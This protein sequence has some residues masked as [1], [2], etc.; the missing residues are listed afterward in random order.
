MKILLIGEYSNVHWT[1]AE[2]LRELGHKVTVLSNGDFWKDYPRDISLVRRPDKIGGLAYMARLY[3][4][5]PRLKGYDIVQIIN[6]AFLELKAERIAPIYRF[7]RR[8]N[9][10]MVLGAF[11]MDAYWVRMCREKQLLRYSDFNIGSRLRTDEVA[12]TDVRDWMGTEKQRLNDLIAAD[13]DAIVAGLYEYWVAYREYFPQKTH[14]VPFPIKLEEINLSTEVP[15]K[16]KL[17][18]GIN[19]TRSQYK[20]TDIMLR[21]ARRAVAEN[22][23]RAELVEAYSVPFSQYREMMQQSHVLLDQL[24]SYTPAMNALEAMAHGMIVVGGGEEEPYQ[25]LGESELRPIVNVTP[26]EDSVYQSL[27]ELISHPEQ[28]PAARR[29]SRLYIERH[30]DHVKVAKQY[31]TIY[32]EILNK[33]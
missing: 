4:L 28:I 24:Y 30:H 6:P 23:D 31:E 17:F 15:Q 21:A 3:M 13:A 29:D 2:G 1:L 8:N 32:N 18:I 33:N 16:I 10:K 7:L 19:K 20:G 12:M 14:F 27:T 5:L 22:A 11:G 26:T 9:R 25:L